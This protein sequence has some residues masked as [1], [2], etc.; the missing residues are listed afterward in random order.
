MDFDWEFNAPHWH[1][2]S[3]EETVN[4]DVWFDEQERIIAAEPEKILEVQAFSEEKVKK[5]K[6]TRIPVARRQKPQGSQEES[7]PIVSR[8]AVKRSDDEHVDRTG[9]LREKGGVRIPMKPIRQARYG[10]NV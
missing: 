8:I 5:R 3:K 7:V 6:Q 2:F 4:P 1:D 9:V 10:A